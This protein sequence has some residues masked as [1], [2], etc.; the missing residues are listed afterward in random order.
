M[1][2]FMHL[3]HIIKRKFILSFASLTVILVN[4]CF[5]SVHRFIKIINFK[6]YYWD[7]ETFYIMI[8]ENLEFL[9]YFLSITQTLL[10]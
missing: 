1:K 3:I 6:R 4:L 7:E 5:T 9:S 2:L 8:F 10:K